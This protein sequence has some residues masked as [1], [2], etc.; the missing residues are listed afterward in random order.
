MNQRMSTEGERTGAGGGETGASRRGTIAVRDAVKRFDGGVLAVDHVSLDVRPGEFVSLIG[1][2]GCGKSTLMRLIADLDAPTSG[3]IS[4]LG[5][6]PEKARLA[7][8]YG[9]AFQQAGLLPW[10]TLQANV[11]LPLTLSIDPMTDIVR[12]HVERLADEVG[13]ARARLSAPAASLTAGARSR[14]SRS[15]S[16]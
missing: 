2:S 3:S 4:V 14:A 5:K 8:D 15:P 10:R 16:R 7:Q 6:T 11:A 13:L 1:P 9:I 12:A